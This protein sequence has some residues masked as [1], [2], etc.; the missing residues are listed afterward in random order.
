MA[1]ADWKVWRGPRN[2][3]GFAIMKQANTQLLSWNAGM[4]AKRAITC[5]PRNLVL[6]VG[7]CSSEGSGKYP[8]KVHFIS[9]TGLV[10]IWTSKIGKATVKRHNCSENWVRISFPTHLQVSIEKHYTSHIVTGFLFPCWVCPERTH[11]A[12]TGE[13][14]DATLYLF[15]RIGIKLN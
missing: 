15:Q 12:A 6:L 14:S 1:V 13:S 2:K 4:N 9:W 10:D 5:S 7:P 11:A 8:D 3:A